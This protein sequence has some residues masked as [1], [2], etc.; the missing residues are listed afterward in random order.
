MSKT[1]NQ[2]GKINITAQQCVCL[3]YTF[4]QDYVPY[5][6]PTYNKCGVCD[7]EIQTHLSISTGTT[8]RKITG[9]N[10]KGRNY[11]T[12]KSTNVYTQ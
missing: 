11:L 2:T 7:R 3:L 9:S 1:L 4:G 8:H 6:V 12:H 10:L 5:Y